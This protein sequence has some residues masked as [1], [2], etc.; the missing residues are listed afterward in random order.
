[1]TPTL[2]RTR[3]P[4]LS[5]Y[6]SVRC[7]PAASSTLC[8]VAPSVHPKRSRRTTI[9]WCWPHRSRHT[10]QELGR[11]VLASERMDP[12]KKATDSAVLPTESESAKTSFQ[13]SP[14]VTMKVV[15]KAE[16]K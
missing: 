2:H 14:L 7:V 11:R 12:P 3:S 13:F 4:A 5:E 8:V 6:F 10:P 9:C 15:M 16:E 1:M